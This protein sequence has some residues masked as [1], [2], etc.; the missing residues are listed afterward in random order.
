MKGFIRNEFD[1]WYWHKVRV[2]IIKQWKKPKRI[3]INLN[4]LNKKFK[5]NF[6]EESIY[7]EANSRLGLVIP[8]DYYLFEQ[9]VNSIVEAPSTR[10]VC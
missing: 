2:V 7:K 3:F 6:D 5:N 9:F 8:L 4:I 1:P 10:P